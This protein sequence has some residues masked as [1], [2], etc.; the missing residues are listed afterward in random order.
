MVS[1]ALGGEPAATAREVEGMA[2]D[3]TKDVPALTD[4]RGAINLALEAHARPSAPHTATGF[5][6][7][8]PSP[9]TRRRPDRPGALV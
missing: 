9:A 1:E 3:A 2:R 5:P 8:S 6:P 7:T 4:V